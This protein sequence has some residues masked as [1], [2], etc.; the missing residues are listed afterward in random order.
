MIYYFTNAV[1]YNSRNVTWLESGFYVT[2]FFTLRTAD[3]TFYGTFLVITNI[4]RRQMDTLI[5]LLRTSLK[6]NAVVL[7]NVVVV[8]GRVVGENFL[9]HCLLT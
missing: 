7:I 2:V 5:W 4:Y 3:N 1:F 9:L 6:I 8:G